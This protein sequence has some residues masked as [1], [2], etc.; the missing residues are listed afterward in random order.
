[1]LAQYEAW[2]NRCGVIPRD[3][4]LRVMADRDENAFWEKS[5]EN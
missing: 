2:A 4:I 5:D 3:Q 1:M